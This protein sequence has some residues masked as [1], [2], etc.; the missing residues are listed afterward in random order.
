MKQ[1]I[2]TILDKYPRIFIIVKTVRQSIN[3][4]FLAIKKIFS[5]K[6]DLRLYSIYNQFLALSGLDGSKAT[7]DI[8]EESSLNTNSYD[9][10]RFLMTIFY[11]QYQQIK[12]PKI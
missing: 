3:H 12:E 1:K 5:S 11:Q 2:K 9:L 6:Y 10:E 8:I 7:V 4:A